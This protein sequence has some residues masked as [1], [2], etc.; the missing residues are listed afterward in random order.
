MPVSAVVELKYRV[1]IPFRGVKF[2]SETV[3]EVSLEIPVD[4]FAELG[5]PDGIRVRIEDTWNDA[6]RK[7]T[8]A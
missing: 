5:S 4:L 7:W 8:N 6:E 1:A 2:Y 3:P